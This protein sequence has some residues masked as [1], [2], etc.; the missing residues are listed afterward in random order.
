[1]SA[2]GLEII[3][4]P[5]TLITTFRSNHQDEGEIPQ[6]LPLVS[7]LHPYDLIPEITQ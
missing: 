5:I 6:A 3:S 4:R 1:M 2:M 7:S